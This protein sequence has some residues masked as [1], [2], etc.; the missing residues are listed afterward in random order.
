M[1]LGG[2]VIAP[3]VF[4]LGQSFPVL[5]AA[6]AIDAFF[7]GNR[8]VTLTY[9]GEIVDASNEAKGFAILGGCFS[10]G[11]VIGPVLGGSLVFPADW[12]PRIFG[13]TIFDSHP[14]LLPNL[15]YAIFAAL[16]WLIGALFL[17]ETLP[18]E[19]RCVRK[20]RA[21]SPLSQGSPSSAT[22]QNESAEA[23]VRSRRFKILA[24]FPTFPKATLQV[25]LA[26]W[27]M[28]GCVA[29]M[30]QLL[31]LV[32][33]FGREVDGFDFGPHQLGMLQNIGAVALILCQSFV[34][35][36]LTKKLGFLATYLIGFVLL[37]LSF[38]F[39]PII[40]LFADPGRYGLLRWIPLG[41]AMFCFTGAAGLTFPT[42]FAFINRAAAGPN[43]GAING[44]TAAGG[45]LSRGCFP[46]LAA[47]LLGQ[48]SRLG[49]FGRYVPFY[50]ATVVMGL[51][52]AISWPGMRKMEKN[53]IGAQQAQQASDEQ[54]QRR[55]RQEPL[56]SE[57][58]PPGE[59]T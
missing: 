21:E 22:C 5:F 37:N 47:V 6:R 19:Q 10:M 7:C 42:A 55:S 28:S 46:P 44:Y 24:I 41:A 30:R 1:G 25:M 2:S 14:F 40:G 4:G 43:R 20:R 17:E 32:L 53:S 12:A 26:Y 18:R 58:D 23:S 31:I 35:A 29:A 33:S 36:P 27:S 49:G 38:S 45:A 50:A 48:C 51:G 9:L 3:V 13:G 56:M 8:G 11:L 54:D 15:T 34:Y 16:V 52:L 39:L 59:S 57:A